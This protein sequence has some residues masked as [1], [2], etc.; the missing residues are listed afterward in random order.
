MTDWQ[1]RSITL[2]TVFLGGGEWTA[3]IVEDGVNAERDATDHVHRTIK[4]K[5]GEP[6]EV[7][8]APGGGWTARFERVH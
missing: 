2:P 8:M 1:P 4:V 5:A 6:L 3:Q 7:K